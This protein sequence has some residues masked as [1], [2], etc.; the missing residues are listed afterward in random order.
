MAQRLSEFDS[1]WEIGEGSEGVADRLNAA[2]Q[3]PEPLPRQTE[4]RGWGGGGGIVGEPDSSPPHP[5][6]ASLKGV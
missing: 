2:V 1:S 5:G 3:E 6:R 4:M